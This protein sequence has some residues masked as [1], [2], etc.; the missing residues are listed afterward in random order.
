MLYETHQRPIYIKRGKSFDFVP[1]AHHF[2]EIMICTQGEYHVSCN[3]KD[4]LLRRGD[5]MI[6]FSNDVHA[7]HSTLKAEGIMMIVSPKLLPPLSAETA[8]RKYENFFLERNEELVHLSERAWEEYR[9][10]G[11]MEIVLGY[12]YV[13]YGTLLKRLSYSEHRESVDAEQFSQIL[14]YVSE[15]YTQKLSLRSISERFGISACHLSRSFTQKLSCNFL[16]YLHSLR[17]E[18]AKNLLRHSA[19]SI[20][21][22]AYDSGFSDQR[23][24]NRVFKELTEQTPKEYRQRH[25]SGGA[26]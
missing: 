23:T 7:Y 11:S 6:A 14:Q 16:H 3:F 5:A 8:A 17:I 25:R 2:I 22:I 18:H 26:P 1:H 21:E 19:L 10:D 20:L 4:I 24:F 9:G 13:I 12:L 15:H